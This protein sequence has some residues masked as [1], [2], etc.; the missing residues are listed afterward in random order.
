M[1]IITTQFAVSDDYNNDDIYLTFT[2]SNNGSIFGVYNNQGIGYIDQPLDDEHNVFIKAKNNDNPIVYMNYNCTS[3]GEEFKINFEKIKY[4]IASNSGYGF[5]KSSQSNSIGF[6][7][8]EEVPNNLVYFNFLNYIGNS[9]T[10]IEDEYQ[11]PDNLFGASNKKVTTI[12]LMPHYLKDNSLLIFSNAFVN[13]P[14][15]TDVYIYGDVTFKE[16]HSNKD[17]VNNNLLHVKHNKSINF[18]F[19]KP[20]KNNGSIYKYDTDWFEVNYREFIQQIITKCESGYTINGLEVSE[21][22]DKFIKKDLKE[23]EM[24]F[25]NFKKYGSDVQINFDNF[26][27]KIPDLSVNLIKDSMFSNTMTSSIYLS[28]KY[29]NSN[30][31]NNSTNDTAIV[32]PSA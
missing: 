25:D 28:R 11:E 1:S 16:A 2:I 18:H 13:Y 5:N 31:T 14:N 15:L 8:N 4:F 6:F 9:Y 30:S 32:N 26:I 19:I 17:G 10:G 29:P 23:E 21:N 7:L 12:V 22:C 24:N 27:Q 20:F 3:T